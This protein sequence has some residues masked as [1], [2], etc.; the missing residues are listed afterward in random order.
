M[1]NPKLR[2]RAA[3]EAIQ[4]D[5]SKQGQTLPAPKHPEDDRLKAVVETTL[6]NLEGTPMTQWGTVITAALRS[7]YILGQA[8]GKSEKSGEDSVLVTETNEAEDI[9]LRFMDRIGERLVAAGIKPED[10]DISLDGEEG[11]RKFINLFA[12]R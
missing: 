4:K 11:G 12:G 5:N 9:G 1:S 6:R 2:A 8:E 10:I 7:A 3:R